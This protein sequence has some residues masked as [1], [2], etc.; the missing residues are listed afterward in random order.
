M[1]LPLKGRGYHYFLSNFINDLLSVIF[2]SMNNPILFSTT[3]FIM[4]AY[5]RDPGSPVNGLECALKLGGLQIFRR[6]YTHPLQDSFHGV[7]RADGVGA[8]AFLHGNGKS[9]TGV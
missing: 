2:I 3:G 7:S 4:S 6:V 5:Y 9:K 8:I 1:A